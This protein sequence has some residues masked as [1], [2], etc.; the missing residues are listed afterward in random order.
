MKCFGRRFS[1]AELLPFIG[2]Q[3]AAAEAPLPEEPAG[4]AATGGRIVRT[5]DAAEAKEAIKRIVRPGDCVL[6]KASRGMA[7]EQAI[8]S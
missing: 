7:L 3:K 8:P 6:L 2:G 1:A 4:E 5:S